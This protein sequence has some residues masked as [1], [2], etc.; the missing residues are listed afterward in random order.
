MEAALPL[1]TAIPIPITC[2]RSLKNHKNTF[3]IV[4]IQEESMTKQYCPV[5]YEQLL[6]ILCIQEICSYVILFDKRLKSDFLHAKFATA[7]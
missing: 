4:H 5:T 1:V 2:L 6:Y 3:K 7:P